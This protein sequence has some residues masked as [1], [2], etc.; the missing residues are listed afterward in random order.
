[1]N[2]KDMFIPNQEHLKCA[3]SKVYS[4]GSCFTTES[5]HKIAQAYNNYI[6]AESNKLINLNLTKSDLVKELT[7]R[8]TNCGTDQLCW[9]DVDWIKRIKDTDIHKN[10]FR[11]KGPQ[12]RFKWLSTTNINEIMKQY[13]DKYNDFKFLGAVP[14]D[15][16]DLTQLNIGGLDFDELTVQTK[17]VGLVINLDEHWKRGS[18]WVGLFADFSKDQILYFDSYGTKPKKRISE[19]VKKIALWCFKRH[20]MG[21]QK[22]GNED[23]EF[24]DTESQF[25]RPNKNKYEESMNI[26]YNKTRHQF[27]NSECGVYSVNFILRMLKGESFENICSNI[28]SDD[29]VNECRKQYFRFK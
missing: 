28:T 3:P 25:M 12:G 5:L 7:N 29:K 15:F 9:L 16:E 10:T 22:G 17:R 2:S 24:I 14:Y 27:K 26:D 6:G 19:F 1:M 21:I 20:H 4:E 18:H 11:P 13:E 8:I 23:L